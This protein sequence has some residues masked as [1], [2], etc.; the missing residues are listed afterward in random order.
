MEQFK[1][2]RMSQCYEK[3]IHTRTP[4]QKHTKSVGPSCKQWMC[5]CVS[6]FYN[7]PQRLSIQ[8]SAR[9]RASTY[10]RSVSHMKRSVVV[11]N[12]AHRE[13][14]SSNSVIGMRAFLLLLLL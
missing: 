6:P 9:I 7:I 4:A 5:M 11:K 2:H 3:A 1:R 14:N 10:A 8:F 12:V 13:W